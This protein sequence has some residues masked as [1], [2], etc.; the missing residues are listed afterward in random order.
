MNT[1]SITTEY[2]TLGQCL[3]M[4]HAVSSGGESKRFL[5][6]NEVWVNQE[7]ETR[8]GRKLYPGMVVT[9]NQTTYEV[10]REA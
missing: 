6:S 3:K 5:Q 10:Q 4:I 9:W 2:I 1:I 7:R 8:R